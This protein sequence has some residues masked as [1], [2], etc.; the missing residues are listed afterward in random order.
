LRN[1][2]GHGQAI[3]FIRV[4]HSQCRQKGESSKASL[5]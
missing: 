3:F 4:P 2:P 1:F 5:F